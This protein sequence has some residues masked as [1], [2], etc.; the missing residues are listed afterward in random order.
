ME[1]KLNHKGNRTMLRTFVSSRSI[2]PFKCPQCNKA[3]TMDVSYYLDLEKVIKVNAKC[4]CGN[5]FKSMLEKR[6]QYRKETNLPG[7]FVHFGNGK[8]QRDSDCM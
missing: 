3:K 7:S 8:E 1:S 2:A 4:P 6:K 5:Q